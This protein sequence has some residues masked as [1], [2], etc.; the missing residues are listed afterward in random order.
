MQHGH[1]TA[2]DPWATECHFGWNGGQT[3]PLTK[4]SREATVLRVG[5]LLPANFSVLSF[6]PIAVFETANGVAG[7]RFYDIHLVSESGERMANS[8]GTTWIP[9]PWEYIYM[10]R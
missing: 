10:T 8:L 3:L 5:L 1:I 6:A 9:N 4:L 2:C 7:E